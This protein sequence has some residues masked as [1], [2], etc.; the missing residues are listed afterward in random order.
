MSAATAFTIFVDENTWREATANPACVPSDLYPSGTLTIRM[1]TPH[2]SELGVRKPKGEFQ[3]ISYKRVSSDAPPSPVEP[4]VFRA[5]TE[6]NIPVD[7]AVGIT[8]RDRFGKSEAIFSEQP[9]TAFDPKR[10]FSV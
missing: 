10:S 6:L 8:V 4:E 9:M 7:S 1:R 3:F 5:Q 2:G